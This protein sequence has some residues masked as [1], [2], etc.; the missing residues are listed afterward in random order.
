[1]HSEKTVDSCFMLPVQRLKAGN[2]R[3]FWSDANEKF[4][5]DFDGHF[6]LFGVQKVLTFLQTMP[7]ERDYMVM[8]MQSRDSLDKTFKGLFTSDLP[9]SKY[10]SR[11]SLELTGVDLSKSVNIP[12]MELL[13]DWTESHELLE[14]RQMLQMPWC[15]AAPVKTGKTQ[16]LL[17]FTKD[18]T[19]SRLSDIVKLFRDHDIVRRVTYLQHT[20]Q[21]DFIVGYMVASNP[22]DEL[23]KSMGSCTHEICDMV[24]KADMEYIG[25][26]Y[27]DPKNIP[28]LKLLFKWDD[29]VGVQTAEQLIA[30]TE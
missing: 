9:C 14:E 16:D 21:G 3:D 30:Y 6:K 8:Y 22:L 11:K 27:S 28:D 5:S 13:M 7:D 2:V 25:I 26:N 4:S 23:I 1:M 19:M 20:S 12:K 10:F 17:K 24:R 18:M 29:T 15:F